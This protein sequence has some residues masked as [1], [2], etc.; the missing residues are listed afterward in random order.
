MGGG[1]RRVV[2]EGLTSVAGGR[3]SICVST[4]RPFPLR[5]KGTERQGRGSASGL[6]VRG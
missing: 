6:G 3:G 1:W 2:A 4:C 5:A